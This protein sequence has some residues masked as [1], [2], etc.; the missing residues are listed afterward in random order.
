[1]SESFAPITFSD[2]VTNDIAVSYERRYIASTAM[3]TSTP[4]FCGFD[5]AGIVTVNTLA[6]ESVEPEASAM[7][8]LLYKEGSYSYDGG[9]HYGTYYVIPAVGV[10]NV[11]FLANSPSIT[12]GQFIVL[13]GNGK[14][15]GIDVAET[16][17]YQIV[18]GQALYPVTLNAE[19][20]QVIEIKLLEPY[21]VKLTE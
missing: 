8:L 17:D 14:V 15:S 7:P 2:N 3:S 10:A 4:V 5:G 9:A 11:T 18:V 16:T 20:D 6:E 12:A 13:A 19:S 1:M 21:A